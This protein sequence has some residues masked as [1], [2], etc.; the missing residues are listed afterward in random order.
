MNSFLFVL[1]A[2]PFIHAA[3]VDKMLNQG[4]QVLSQ[5]KT[6]KMVKECSCPIQRECVNSMKQQVQECFDPC[7][8][9]VKMVA[10]DPQKL[11]QCFMSKQYILENMMSCM[12][13]NLDSCADAGENKMIPHT[14]IRELINTGEQQIQSAAKTFLSAMVHSDENLINTALQV[15]TCMKECFMKKNQDGFCFDKHGCQ[16]L[17]ESR[18]AADA[19]KKCMR[20]IHW[21]KN[22]SDL[23]KCSQDAG[24]TS[25]GEFCKILNIAGSVAQSGA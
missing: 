7:W 5:A 10:K 21:K 9:S 6:G 15:A 11:K 22:A 14:D 19:S 16:I 23:C 2:L 13:R 12:E 25:F 1:L 8:T 3:M 18:D 17:I 24:V 20:Q 4:A